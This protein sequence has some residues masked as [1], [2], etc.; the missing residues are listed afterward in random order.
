MDLAASL[1]PSAYFSHSTA[2]YLN[3]LTASLPSALLTCWLSSD[4]IGLSRWHPSVQCW[5]RIALFPYR[6]Q[7]TARD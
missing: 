3:G 7:Y 4:Q 6:H 2:A 1:R 5:R